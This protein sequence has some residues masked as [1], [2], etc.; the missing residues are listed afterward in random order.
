MRKTFR[1]REYIHTNVFVNV[2]IAF[3]RCL[4]G[5][6]LFTKILKILIS[7]ISTIKVSFFVCVRVCRLLHGFGGTCGPTGRWCAN[8]EV[9]I[10]GV[11]FCLCCWWLSLASTML[12]YPSSDTEYCAV[13]DLSIKRI[14]QQMLGAASHLRIVF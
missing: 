1:V 11:F 6:N 4:R 2:Q 3:E 5:K 9:G 8:E 13:W 10:I 14:I 12:Y 7:S